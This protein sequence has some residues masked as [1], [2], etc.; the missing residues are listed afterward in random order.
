MHI[1]KGRRMKH[2]NV[3]WRRKRRNKINVK[4]ETPSWKK[5]LEY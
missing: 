4:V 5:F 3:K 1:A 2:I